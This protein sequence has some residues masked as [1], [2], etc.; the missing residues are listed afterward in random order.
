LARTL[1][2]GGRMTSHLSDALE[3]LD[4]GVANEKELRLIRWAR[5]AEWPEL[6]PRKPKYETNLIDF[7]VEFDG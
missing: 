1:R 5:G 4:Q 6:V 3:N 2:L 7:S